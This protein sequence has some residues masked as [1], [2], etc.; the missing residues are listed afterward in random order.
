MGNSLREMEPQYLSPDPY[1]FPYSSLDS[2]RS[3]FGLTSS[4]KKQNGCFNALKYGG[5]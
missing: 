3:F 4:R 1:S 5:D 2:F